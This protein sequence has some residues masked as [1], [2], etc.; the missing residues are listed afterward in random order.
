MSP[1]LIF[2]IFV[3]T[4]TITRHSLIVGLGKVLSC[5]WRWTLAPL[6]D[7]RLARD[8][9]ARVALD[10][11]RL[12][13]PLPCR[14]LGDDAVQRDVAPLADPHHPADGLRKD[15]RVISGNLG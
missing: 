11:V 7:H 3:A 9:L 5:E 12:D 1:A 8:P 13:G 2:L 15:S 10:D 4:A 6:V 14:P